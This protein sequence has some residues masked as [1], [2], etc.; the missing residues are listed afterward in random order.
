[1]A[2]QRFIG[3]TCDVEL[4]KLALSAFLQTARACSVSRLSFVRLVGH[5]GVY[6]VSYEFHDKMVKSL[7]DFGIFRLLTSLDAEPSTALLDIARVNDAD[8]DTLN[9][10]T[11]F[12][13]VYKSKTI[14]I[15]R[16]STTIGLR[17]RDDPKNRVGGDIVQAV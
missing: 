16:V 12:P 15:I 2:R 10:H 11:L 17:L 8:W 14:F 1:M 13:G 6:G 9:G 4:S 3:H 7:V 5:C